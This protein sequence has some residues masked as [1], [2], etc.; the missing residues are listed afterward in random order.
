[1]PKSVNKVIL[2]GHLG[3]DPEVKYTPQ[4]TA[5]AKTSIATNSSYKDK[6]GNWQERVEWHNLVMWSRLA[7]VAGEYLHKGSQIYIE[8]HLQTRSW[9][10]KQTNQKKYMT[11][12]VVDDLVMCG[13]RNGESGGGG[14]RQRQSRDE[15]FDSSAVTESNPITDE[16]IPF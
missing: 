11:E 9:D 3:K 5:V 7:E 12:V 16:D 4:G 13:A 2:L 1:M 10:D 8:G 15:G 6:S 14:Q